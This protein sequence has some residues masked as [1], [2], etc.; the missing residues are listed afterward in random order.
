M[1][2]MSVIVVV[3]ACAVSL[4]GPAQA[5]PQPRVH[6]SN[7]SRTGLCVVHV[8][9]P[10]H[11]G[12]RGTGSRNGEVHRCTDASGEVIPCA[13]GAL[14]EWDQSL[15]CYLALARPQPPK[16]AAV[17]QGHRTGAIYLCTAWP[18][19]STG[20]TE[21]WLRAQPRGLDPRALAVQAE[22]QLVVPRPSGHRSP[23]ESQRFDG[24]PFTYVN[25]WTWFWTDRG[26]WRS[27]SATARA[28]GLSATVTVQPR[29][30]IFDP[31][32]GSAAVIC[33]GPGRPWRT[34]DGDS[35]P[36]RGGCGSRY[37]SATQTPLVSTQSIRWSVS[38]RA[39]DGSSGSLP[40]LTTS[41]SG[42]LMVLQI[43][44]VVTR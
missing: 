43:Q 12:S 31:G 40:A 13:R 25:L 37:R 26:M 14:G 19:A 39:S 10:G 44:S 11:G 6:C 35:A 42:R 5:H 2:R 28:G 24:E 34:R 32:D 15:G 41:R 1:F 17:W 21:I 27:R 8:G 7:P 20:A 18:P 4:A 33:V 22:R 23:S 38:W 16:S 30:L 29:A 36:S 9:T 3:A